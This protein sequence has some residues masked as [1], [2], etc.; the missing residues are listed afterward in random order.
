[1]LEID[2]GRYNQF[3]CTNRLQTNINGGAITFQIK[4][5]LDPDDSVLVE[6]KN[7]GAG[8]GPTEI[9]DVDLSIGSIRLKIQEALTE[10]IN[11][12]WHWGEAMVTI[13]GEDYLLFQTPVKMEKVLI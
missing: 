2:I 7:T 8:G 9:E 11:A 5:T 3:L 4:K 12:G 1:M 10:N 13:S 6:L